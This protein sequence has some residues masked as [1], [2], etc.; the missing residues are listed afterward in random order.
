MVYHLGLLGHKGLF[1]DNWDFFE[2]TNFRSSGIILS[3]II[4]L[5]NEAWIFGLLLGSITN[6][7]L[8]RAIFQGILIFR[9]FVRYS[10]MD[11]VNL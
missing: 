4:L 10:R 11:N 5:I 3:I 2:M 7:Q 1:Q 9:G 6:G 8:I